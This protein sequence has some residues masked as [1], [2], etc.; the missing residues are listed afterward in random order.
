MLS[1]IREFFENTVSASFLVFAFLFFILVDFI[2]FIF[3]FFPLLTIINVILSGPYEAIVGRSIVCGTE[4]SFLDYVLSRLLALAICGIVILLLWGLW[5]LFK[6]ILHFIGIQIIGIFI[7]IW[8]I[9]KATFVMIFGKKVA[10]TIREKKSFFLLLFILCI[11]LILIYYFFPFIKSIAPYLLMCILA[12]MGIG[13]ICGV[14]WVNDTY[15][16]KPIVSFIGI[17]L[18]VMFLKFFY[19]ATPDTNILLT[20]LGVLSGIAFIFFTPFLLWSFISLIRVL[21]KLYLRKRRL[22]DTKTPNNSN[23]TQE[24]E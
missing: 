18:L 24:E 4:T 5:S 12:L 23:S 6:C 16:W 8:N 14:M 15:G 13:I 9:I 1:R 3:P 11:S 7:S 21:L 20:I 17:V 10:N 19:Y 22:N 2:C